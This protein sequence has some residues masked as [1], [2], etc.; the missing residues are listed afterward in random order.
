[1]N[2]RV[3]AR[4]FVASALVLSLMSQA[5]LAQG[6]R[7]SGAAAGGKG[8]SARPAATPSITLP[9]EKAAT[10]ASTAPRQ[11]DYIVAVVNSEPVTNNEVRARLATALERSKSTM[12]ELQ[13]QAIA[14]AKA[15][16]RK[17]DTVIREHPYESLGVAFGV[18]LV[19]GVLVGR[20]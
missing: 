3:T 9:P 1:M 12:A 13:S 17:A 10:A 15:A 2:Q 16:A 11:A 6:L 19:I 4:A 14:G 18:G 20:R 8:L 5:A 7:P